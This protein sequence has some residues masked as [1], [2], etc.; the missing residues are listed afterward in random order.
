MIREKEKMNKLIENTTCPHTVTNVA[1]WQEAVPKAPNI[2]PSIT[3][4]RL[5][6]EWRHRRAGLGR[7]GRSRHFVTDSR[8]NAERERN[9]GAA[10]GV[11]L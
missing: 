3:R 10:H 5:L 9:S 1:M 8:S 6:R 4:N 7:V 11:S 2:E